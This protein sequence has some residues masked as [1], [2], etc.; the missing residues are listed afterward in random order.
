MWLPSFLFFCRGLC[1][2]IF[3]FS[4]GYVVPNFVWTWLVYI[5]FG[6]S[7]LFLGGFHS[8]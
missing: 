7:R 4:G 6:V 3:C 5:F 2:Y 8:S 1:G